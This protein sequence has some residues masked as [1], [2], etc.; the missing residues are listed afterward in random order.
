M[1]DPRP[2][3]PPLD[4]VALRAGL[5]EPWRRLDVVEETGSTNADLLARAAGGEAIGGAVLLA[6]YQ[7]AGRGRHGRQWSAPPRSQL[8]LSVGVDASGVPA[9]SWGWLPLATGVAVVDAVAEVTGVRVGLKWPND[10]LVG[11]AGGKLAGILAEVASP[12]PV[13]VVGLGLNVSMTAEEAPDARATSLSQL[14]AGTVDRN[15]LARALLRHLAVRFEGWRASDP[16]LAADYRARSVTIGS[17]VRAILP[18]DNELVGT[19]VD[20]DAVG[21]LIIDTG[22]ERVTVSAGDITHLRPDAP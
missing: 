4:V 5:S 19:A 6:E 3:R 1:D 8:A 15:P 12:A 22:T 14:G 20:V 18:G 16:K 21:R 11:R 7:N 17:G 2:N 10:V 13:V 9:D